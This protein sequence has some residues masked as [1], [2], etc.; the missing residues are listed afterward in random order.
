MDVVFAKPIPVEDDE[1]T[2]VLWMMRLNI[3]MPFS[4]MSVSFPPPMIDDDDD[5][6]DDDD[7]DDAK[8]ST[9]SSFSDVVDGT[10]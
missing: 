10:S 5:D 1:E 6:D 8:I 2:R 3:S 9:T 4:S 7:M